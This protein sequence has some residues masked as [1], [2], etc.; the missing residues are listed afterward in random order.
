VVRLLISSQL[1]KE[2]ETPVDNVYAQDAFNGSPDLSQ[3]VRASSDLEEV[4]R[5]CEKCQKMELWKPNFHVSETRAEL[6]TMSSTCDFCRMRWNQCKRRG[7]IGATVHFSKVDST[8]RLNERYPPVLALC[9]P[10]GRLLA[11]P[12]LFN[13]NAAAATLTGNLA[14]L[15]ASR[16]STKCHPSR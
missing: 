11:K 2:W 10:P 7:P 9:R 3:T 1:S 13:A 16:K 12:S 8:L 4:A 5:L 14:D 6:E 15:K